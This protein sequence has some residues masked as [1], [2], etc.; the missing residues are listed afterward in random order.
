MRRAFLA[1]FGAGLV[2]VAALALSRFRL[3]HTPV[4]EPREAILTLSPD[5]EVCQGPL[6]PGGDVT[7]DAVRLFT[8]AGSGPLMVSLRDSVG[9]SFAT[10]RGRTI[11]ADDAGAEPVVV[12]LPEIR[13]ARPFSVCVGAAGRVPV[14]VWGAPGVASTETSAALDGRPAAYDVALSL[15][16]AHAR[17]LLGEMPDVAR[18]ASVFKPTWVSPALLALLALTVLAAVPALV[19]HALSR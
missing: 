7:F 19:L 18:R 2:L 10:G 16:H 3:A 8:S 6:D 15:E 14:T 11:P 17:T 1:A 5:H 13:S 4:A 9:R 12:A